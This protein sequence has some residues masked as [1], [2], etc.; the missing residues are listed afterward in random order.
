V[1]RGWGM[2]GVEEHNSKNKKLKRISVVK[3]KLTE[4]IFANV[5]W[6]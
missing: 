4:T 6:L 2:R 5:I 3:N 1:G